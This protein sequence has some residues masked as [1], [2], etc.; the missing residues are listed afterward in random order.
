M[1]ALSEHFGPGKNGLVLFDIF[2]SSCILNFTCL[3]AKGQDIIA[4]KSAFDLHF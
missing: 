1:Y 3:G 2:N 4:A